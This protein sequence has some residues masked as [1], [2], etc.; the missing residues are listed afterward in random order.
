MHLR[1]QSD[2]KLHLVC[3]FVSKGEVT[4]HQAVSLCA[5]VADVIGIGGVVTTE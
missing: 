5:T 1:L 4:V 3:I 2:S